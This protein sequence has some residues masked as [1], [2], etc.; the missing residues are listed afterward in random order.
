MVYLRYYLFEYY[1]LQTVLLYIWVSSKYTR[2][3]VSFR[4]QPEIKLQAHSTLLLYG[5]QVLII[6]VL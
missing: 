2:T 1:T 4:E 6:N 3:W 5:T